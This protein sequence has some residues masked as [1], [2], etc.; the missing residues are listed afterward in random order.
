MLVNNGLLLLPSLMLLPQAFAPN[1][2][3]SSSDQDIIF[4]SFLH[5]LAPHDPRPLIDVSADALRLAAPSKQATARHSAR[6]QSYISVRN[7]ST[8]LQTARRDQRLSP[9]PDAV[10]IG[11]SEARGQYPL[12]RDM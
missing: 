5:R 1:K 4:D 11:E 7:I 2:V 10:P 9:A 8:S 6:S 3:N 12:R